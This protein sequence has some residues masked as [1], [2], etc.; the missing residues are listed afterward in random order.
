MNNKTKRISVLLFLFILIGIYLYPIQT[1]KQCGEFYLCK[2][3]FGV[4]ICD[5]TTEAGEGEDSGYLGTNLRLYKKVGGFK[6]Y[7]GFKDVDC[8]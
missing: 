8:Y 7:L 6:E 2:V 3:K 4:Y 1:E 5:V